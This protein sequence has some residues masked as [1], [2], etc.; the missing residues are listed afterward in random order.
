M[1]WSKSGYYKDLNYLNR[2]LRNVVVI[3]KSKEKV[4]NHKRNVKVLS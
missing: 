1:C 4:K 3:D 2:D